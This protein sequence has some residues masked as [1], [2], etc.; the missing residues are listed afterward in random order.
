MAKGKLKLCTF[1]QNNEPLGSER[2][3]ISGLIQFP[4]HSQE[5]LSRK[6]IKQYPDAMRYIS[7]KLPLHI[8]FGLW[9][10]I[11][12]HSAVLA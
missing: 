12:L 11:L 7:F 1:Q 8:V 9:H 6:K 2:Y 10:S 4:P 5:E 3:R